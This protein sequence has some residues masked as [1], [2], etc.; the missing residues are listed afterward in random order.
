MLKGISPLLSSTDDTGKYANI[1]SKKGV[2]PA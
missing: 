2:T 1:L